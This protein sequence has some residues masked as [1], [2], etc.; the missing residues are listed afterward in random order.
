MAVRD[1][2]DRMTRKPEIPAESKSREHEHACHVPEGSEHGD[3][4]V[5]EC[6]AIYDVVFTGEKFKYGW[7]RPL[8]EEK[9]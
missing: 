1:Q 7:V 5:C 3:Q 4:C 8:Q 9:S 2:I 6:G